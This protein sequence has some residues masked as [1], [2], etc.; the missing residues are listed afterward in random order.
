MLKSTV[1]PT[2]LVDGLDEIVKAGS[3]L[4]SALV[5]PWNVYPPDCTTVTVNVTL[6][7]LDDVHVGLLDDVE[8][9]VPCAP[10]D[11]QAYEY[12]PDPPFTVSLKDRDCPSSIAVGEAE[13]VTVGTWEK[14]S[15][16][17][18]DVLPSM[19]VVHV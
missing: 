12:P 14:I 9:N 4:I 17:P 11:V 6:P 16:V 3:E 15:R 10:D 13:G 7:V 2:S 8:E 19:V 1:C 5:V 18:D